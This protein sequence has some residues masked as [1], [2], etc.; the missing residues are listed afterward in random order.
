MGLGEI[1]KDHGSSILFSPSHCELQE[2]RDSSQCFLRKH[3]GQGRWRDSLEAVSHSSYDTGTFVERVLTSL[4]L[5][6]LVCKME[7]IISTSRG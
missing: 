7:V 3:H 6:F 1:K 5:S 2:E 4:S